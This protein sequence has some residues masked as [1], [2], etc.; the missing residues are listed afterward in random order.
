MSMSH[1]PVVSYFF[2]N[3][4][5]IYHLGNSHPM[6]PLRVAITDE[7]VQSYGLYPKMKVYD[8]SFINVSDDDLTVFHSTEYIDLIKE[9]STENKSLYEDVLH[10]FN[11]GEDCPVID[12]LYEY[13]CLYASGS[14][15]GAQLLN[16]KN[17]D[18]AINW[19]GGLHHAKK[20]EASGF[21]YVND[22]VLAILELLK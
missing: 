18:I 6:K 9:I 8:K 2:D 12:S 7:L 4:I 11:F 13:C 20:C 22:C 3:E 21:C 19:S 17:T 16:N 1:K 15:L 10:Q 14:I 5:G